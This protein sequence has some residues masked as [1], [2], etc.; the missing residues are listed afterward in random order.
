MF[1]AATQ[2]FL[3]DQCNGS[4]LTSAT[5]P[6]HAAHARHQKCFKKTFKQERRRTR[7][8]FG[9]VKIY[10]NSDLRTEDKKALNLEMSVPCLPNCPPYYTA[11]HSPSSQSLVRQKCSSSLMLPPILQTRRI[12]HWFRGQDA[13]EMM[14]QILA[15][16][17]KA[18][19]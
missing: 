9:I 18:D 3:A 17:S 5:Q 11:A 6:N 4:V 1:I 19:S 14:H 13:R 16:D 12:E 7:K 10:A 15:Q 2:R 8:I